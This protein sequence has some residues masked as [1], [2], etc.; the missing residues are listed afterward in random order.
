MRS[1]TLPLLLFL[2]RLVWGTVGTPTKK[3][4][5]TR[6]NNEMET[7]SS[8]CTLLS[9]IESYRALARSPIPPDNRKT[10]QDDVNCRPYCTEISQKEASISE[11]HVQSELRTGDALTLTLPAAKLQSDVRDLPHSCVR[12]QHAGV[13]QCTQYL[14]LYE[15]STTVPP[16]AD[17]VKINLTPGMRYVI[18]V[19]ADRP[20]GL[21]T[22]VVSSLDRE[23]QSLLS[24][25]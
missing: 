9:A 13:V 25:M 3:Q 10:R 6:R 18:L 11:N 1:L 17:L 8:Q 19:S 23:H 5:A 14:S 4:G 12:I 20:C 7:H 16:F 2:F 22:Y 15:R 24:N 21:I